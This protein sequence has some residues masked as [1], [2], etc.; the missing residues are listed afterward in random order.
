MATLKKINRQYLDDFDIDKNFYKILYRPGYAVQARELNQQ[1]AI[2]Q[3]QVKKFGEHIFKDGTIVLGG[4]FDI[5]KRVDYVKVTIPTNQVQWF[6]GAKIRGETSNVTA[7]VIH[8]E[9]DDQHQIL[10]V[11]YTDSNE[12]YSKFQPEELINTVNTQVSYTATALADTEVT[13]IGSLFGI[14]E[15]TLFYNGYFINFPSQSVVTSKYTEAQNVQVV[16]EVEFFTITSRDDETLLDNAQGSPNYKAPGADRLSA[17]LTLRA[18]D[19][20]AELPDNYC[21]LFEIKDGAIK[22]DRERTEYSRVYDELAKRTYDE[23]GDYVVRGMTSY[24]REHLDTGSNGGRLTVENGGDND[25]IS[26]GIES[27]LAYVKGYEISNSVTEYVDIPKSTEYKNVNN[28]IN[29]VRSSNYILVNEIT[30]ALN[31]NGFQTID[32]YDQAEL[33]KTNGVEYTVAPVGN[34]IGTATVRTI[35]T[36][37]EDGE[38]WN[39]VYIMNTDVNSGYSIDDVR[40]IA[41]STYFG[42]VIT[43]ID[44][45][46]VRDTSS[47][48]LL[49]GTS[50]RATRTIRSESGS[51]D[52]SFT[53]S[54]T[55]TVESDTAGQFTITTPLLNET[56]PY[57]VGELFSLAKGQIVVSV[58][59]EVTSSVSGTITASGSTT[60]TGSGTNFL[61]EFTVGERILATSTN[62]VYTISDIISDTEL[63]L[64]ESA[65]FTDEAF[66]KIFLNGDVINLAGNGADGPRSVIADTNSLQFDLKEDFSSVVDVMVTYRVSINEA[67]E[68]TKTLYPNRLVIIDLD[69]IDSVFNIN[70]GVSDVYQIKS[71]RYS[72]AMFN[73]T[74]DGINVTSKYTLDDGQRDL[75][76]DHASLI[77]KTNEYTTGYL[78]V[79][80][81]YFEHST[82]V[83]VGYFSI[84]SYPIDD[85]NPS[86]NTIL[87][88]NVPRFSSPTDGNVYNLRN[89]LDFR[90]SVQM[91]AADAT[92]LSNAS[93]N[94]AESNNFETSS[95]VVIPTPGS[96]VT[97]DFSYYLSRKDVIVVTPQG[98]FRAILGTPSNYPVFPSVEGEVMGV[99]QVLVPPYPSLAGTFARILKKESKGV[100]TTRIMHKRYSMRDIGRLDSRIKNLEYYNALNMLEKSASDLTIPDENGLDR[101]KNGFFVDGFMDHSLGQQSNSNYNIAVDP[102]DQLIRPVFEMSN[103]K[104]KNNGVMN[105]VQRNNGLFSLKYSE[106]PLLEQNRVTTFRNIEQSVFRYIGRIT[107]DPKVDTWVD[108]TVSD[109]TIERGDLEDDFGITK[110]EGTTTEW[111][112]WSSSRSYSTRNTNKYSAYDR[113]FG[114]RKKSVTSTDRLIGNFNSFSEA[115]YA[116]RKADRRTKVVQSGTAEVTNVSGTYRKPIYTTVNVEREVEELGTFVTDVSVIPYIRPQKIEVYV[117]GLKANTRFFVFFD[118]EEMNDYF[119]PYELSAQGEFEDAVK[120][121]EGGD[122]RSNEFGEVFGYLRLPE[123]G[124]RF[125]VGTKKVRLTDSPTN[126][127][128]ATSYADRNFVA[129]GLGVKK[130]NTVYSTILDA[131]QETTE[132]PTQTISENVTTRSRSFQDVDILGPSCM[133][134][135][136]L[137]DVPEEE[138]GVFLTS[139]DVFI[140]SLHPELGVWF[141]IREMDNGGGIKRSQ[142][143]Y[144]EVWM[145]RDDPRLKTS[146]D[147]SVAT[148]VNF[149]N[150]VFLFNNTQYAF[151]IH[152]EGL[153]PDTYFFVSRLGEEDLNTGEQVTGRQ[154]TGTTFTTNNNL[155]WDVVPDV[156]LTVRFNRAEFDNSSAGTVEFA[157]GDYEFIRSSDIADSSFTI[158]DELEGSNYF[159][160]SNTSGSGVVT[161]GDIVRGQASSS[162]GVV[163]NVNGNT[164]YTDGFGFAQGELVRLFDSNG[165]TKNTTFNISSL[166]GGT[167]ELIKQNRLTDK[168]IINKSNGEFFE[169]GNIR[170]TNNEVIELQEFFDYPYH[171]V[172]FDSGTLPFG[173]SDFSFKLR[174]V[175]DST[176]VDQTEPLDLGDNVDHELD[177]LMVLE[178]KSVENSLRSG[179]KSFKLLTTMSSDSTYV[180]PVFDEQV[181]SAIFVQN[182]INDDITNE[183]QPSGGNL[184]NTYIS[185]TVILDEG[186]TAQDFISYLSVYRPPNSDIYV[187]LR[188]KNMNDIESISKKSWIQLDQI[189]GNISSRTNDEDFFEYEY[190]IPESYMTGEYGEFQ[191]T[192]S[193]G[194]THTGYDIFEVK[195][196]LS[197]TDKV[198]VPKVADLRAIALQV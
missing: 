174:T 118:G 65:T 71:I 21:K 74:T 180:S 63:E 176:K 178:S 109:K 5:Q 52:T 152:T 44:D 27:G 114:D 36:E 55:D 79:T 158:G 195:I 115:R 28:Q 70:L 85:E 67:Y 66:S 138:T 46:V 170:D 94:P 12:S 107:L 83:G 106:V 135:S 173:E 56:M 122:I 139:V 7:Q 48:S 37:M 151:V 141:E 131:T 155:N 191:Y 61:N 84:D 168:M 167:G 101:F 108:E 124:K 30:G 137:V 190:H 128:D 125:R 185:K 186:Q 62:D 159:T 166:F 113:T 60:V 16:F 69:N 14:S 97:Y 17:S 162:E 196:G 184:T 80:L 188:V 75:Y 187:W 8:I 59:S 19:L 38:Q 31:V 26:I 134:Y 171:L 127:E 104:L 1:Q 105:N 81:D 121:T 78:L 146:D 96:Q 192:D 130:Q 6:K 58:Q 51:S 76:Y 145:K 40:A 165:N 29:T 34:K 68:R 98:E 117:Q 161:V 13:G 10:Y 3:N 163:V 144:S 35:I 148:N 116:A 77:A 133:A 177:Q 164:V 43:T 57:G 82:S 49:V 140:Q 86:D 23:S 99:C 181:M 183:D 193:T 42:D 198:Y 102:G 110:P 157:I 136:F 172:N 47:Q 92:D 95:N 143:P 64:T 156:D 182:I 22:E 45:K 119:T 103:F 93:V 112:T 197:G 169:G 194:R 149:E 20:D 90:P 2:L 15:G 147:A 150:P 53:F 91:T 25:L 87:T 189:G 120:G 89:F 4:S 54:R 154:L 50:E 41:T 73:D 39:R 179:R 18:Y 153:N 100:Q 11:R 129:N 142:V 33:R 123:E 132:G 72:S 175:L 9:P 88:T 24:S 32:L 126:A 160:T 111:K